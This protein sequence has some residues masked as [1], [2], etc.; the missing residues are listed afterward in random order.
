LR[1]ELAGIDELTDLDELGTAGVAN[2]V[3]RADV[4]AISRWG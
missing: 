3:D 1:S 2:E 4:L